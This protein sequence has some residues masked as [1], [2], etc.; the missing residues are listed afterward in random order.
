MYLTEFNTI[1]DFKNTHQ[2]KNR[3]E[4]LQPVKGIYEKPVSTTI[5]KDKD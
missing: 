5:F 3:G 4:L 2:T 1:W